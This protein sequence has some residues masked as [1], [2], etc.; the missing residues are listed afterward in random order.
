M[1]VCVCV[2]VYAQHCGSGLHVMVVS[3]LVCVVVTRHWEI[4]GKY[5]SLLVPSLYL[6][7]MEN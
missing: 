5:G 4:L 7:L 2:C 3:L 1:C 6:Q